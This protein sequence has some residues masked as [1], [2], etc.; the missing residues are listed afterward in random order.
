MA[1]NDGDQSLPEVG[2]APLIIDVEFMEEED[3]TL[4]E[5]LDSI[6]EIS[7]SRSKSAMELPTSLPTP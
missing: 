6:E 4:A 1:S 3:E 5:P 7:F 2:K